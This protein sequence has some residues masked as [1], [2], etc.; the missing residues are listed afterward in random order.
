MTTQEFNALFEQTVEMCRE[1]LCAKADE[2]AEV[3]DRLHNFRVA[4][5]VMGC[6]VKQALAGMMSKH[7]VS[8]YDLIRREAKGQAVSVELWNEK[9]IDHINYLILLRA[10]VAEQ[11]GVDQARNRAGAYSRLR[12]LRTLW[13]GH[14]GGKR[15]GMLEMSTTVN[16]HEMQSYN[17][18]SSG[19]GLP[20][21]I[22]RVLRLCVDI[23]HERLVSQHTK[24]CD[25]AL[26][27]YFRPE[28]SADVCVSSR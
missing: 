6:D 25:K 11:R 1:T 15:N 8:V 22:D 18:S 2:Y 23:S 20:R 3:D 24:P 9:I 4:A 16:R 14:P 21:I 27:V 19:K 10:A 17:V 28:A 5:A 26:A 13:R 12:H 7:T